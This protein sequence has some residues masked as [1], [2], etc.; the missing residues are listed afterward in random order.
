MTITIKNIRPFSHGAI[1]PATNIIIKDSKIFSIGTAVEGKVFDGAGCICSAGYIDIH[2]H[3]G[4]GSDCMEATDEA[5]STIANYHLKNG[6]TSFCPTTM[7]AAIKDINAALSCIRN[8]HGGGAHIIGA[9][10]EGPFLSA[11]NAGAHPPQFLLAPTKSN[12]QFVWDN[13]DVVTRITIAPDLDCASNFTAQAAEKG[14]QVSLGHDNS[15]DDEINACIVSGA[16]SVTHLY[17]CTSRP[18]RRTT[19]HKHLGLTEIALIDN[20]IYCEVIADNRHV[21]NPL[22]GM[23]FKLK[24]A[25][26]ICLVS[27]SLSVAGMGEGDLYIGSGESKQLIRVEE[28]VAVLPALNTYAGSVTPISKMACDLIKEGYSIEDCLKMTTLNPA[29]LINRHD[30]GD[31]AVGMS[32]DVNIL[33]NNLELVATVFDN[34]IIN[35]KEDYLE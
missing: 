8:Y 12:S 2:T 29:R 14:I 33:T 15:I 28:N 21:P 17:N 27:D 9:H 23:I 26:K 32:S 13:L 18:S 24:S 3:G 20:S 22:L 7:T 5:L 4:A 19:P 1:L 25:D 35:T 6:V 11:K 10:L 16:T 34:K 30:I 31:I